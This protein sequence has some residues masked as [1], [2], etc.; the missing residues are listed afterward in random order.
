MN[1]LLNIYEFELKYSES[2]SNISC[3]CTKMGDGIC[4]CALKN[5]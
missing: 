5:K 3:V 2:T 4:L 1:I